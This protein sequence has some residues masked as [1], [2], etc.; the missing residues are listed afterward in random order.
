MFFYSIYS[1]SQ[2]KNV[3]YSQQPSQ[4]LITCQM[5]FCNFIN[6]N[7]GLEFYVKQER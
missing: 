6:F 4:A 3:S 7:N 5:G 2:L 1:F